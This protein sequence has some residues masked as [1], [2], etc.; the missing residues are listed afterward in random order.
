MKHETFNTFISLLSLTVACITAWFQFAPQEDSLD[1][2][3]QNIDIDKYAFTLVENF[4]LPKDVPHPIFPQDRLAGPAFWAMTIYNKIDRT[5]TVKDIHTYLN[6]QNGGI[7]WYS[8]MNVHLYDRNLKNLMLPISIKAHEAE[9]IIISLN[10]PV[11]ND[12]AE[13]CF[14]T[15]S[16]KSI[17]D[18]YFHKGIDLFGN[19]VS[20]NEYGITTWKQVNL[21]PRFTANI[22]TGENNEFSK[23]FSFFQSSL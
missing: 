9:S 8:N 15:K 1:V 3:I 7:A 6:T 20:Q 14:F 13:Q 23:K 18:C 17:Q 5:I 11:S 2:N 10:I 16:F 22:T 4:Q 19:K 21:T 12:F